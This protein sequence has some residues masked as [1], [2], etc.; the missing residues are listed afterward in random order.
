MRLEAKTH[1]LVADA[2]QDSARGGIDQVLW[3]DAHGLVTFCEDLK[4]QGRLLG[5]LEVG[6][7]LVEEFSD[8]SLDHDRTN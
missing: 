2:A 4:E 6:G 1:D 7:Q 5:H 3:D 8:Y